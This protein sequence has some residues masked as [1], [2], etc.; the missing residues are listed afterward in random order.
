MSVLNAESLGK[1]D[2]QAWM[3]S[4]CVPLPQM[5]FHPWNVCLFWTVLIVSSEPAFQ[6]QG[7]FVFK[8]P[9]WHVNN[10]WIC[11]MSTAACKTKVKKE[12]GSLISLFDHKQVSHLIYG[13]I[14]RAHVPCVNKRET[15]KTVAWECTQCGQLEVWVTC[16]SERLVSQDLVVV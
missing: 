13:E 3:A 9:K 8:D 6:F 14:C 7:S 4:V 2:W 11:T 12:P 16:D 15:G 10:G 5:N 1:W